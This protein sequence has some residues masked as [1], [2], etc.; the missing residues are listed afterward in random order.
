MMVV[1]LILA[2]LAAFAAPA[3]NGLIR[4]QKVRSAA[5]DIFSDLSYA[6]A[7]AI[8]RGHSIQVASAGGSDWSTG[9]ALRD[10]TTGEVIRQQGKLSDGIVFKG[11]LGSVTYDRN[12][13]ISGTVN[14]AFNIAHKESANDEQ[15][16]CVRVSPSGRPN[17]L[18]G[19]CP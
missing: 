4:T 16:R 15:K 6:R 10:T 17:S 1:V 12:G 18:N 13:R 7:E 3:M 2:I 8:N 5:Y 11:D 9:W 19:V 14:V